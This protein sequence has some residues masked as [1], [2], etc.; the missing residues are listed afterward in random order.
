MFRTVK[1]KRAMRSRYGR[2]VAVIVAL[3]ASATIRPQAQTPAAGGAWKAT[4]ASGL[5][6]ADRDANGNA[7]ATTYE[8]RIQGNR[9]TSAGSEQYI[10]GLMFIAQQS[11]N[12]G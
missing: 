4:G 2:M 12:A 11:Q 8:V 9:L 6:K 3:G 10:A 1:E 5:A 7:P